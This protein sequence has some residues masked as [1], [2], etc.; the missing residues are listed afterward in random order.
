MITRVVNAHRHPFVDDGNHVWIDRRSIFGNHP[1][2]ITKDCD[3]EEAVRMY[4]VYFY[5]RIMHDE[6]FCKAVEELKGKTLV[7]WCKPLECHGDVIQEYL[8]H[9]T[10]NDR[11]VDCGCDVVITK[12]EKYTFPYGVAEERINLSCIVPARMCTECYF[13]ILDWVSEELIDARIQ[14]YLKEGK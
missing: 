11:C 1:F 13:R 6:K 2:K 4:R 12:V 8:E 9:M 3:R 14:K 10:L 5:N 7:C